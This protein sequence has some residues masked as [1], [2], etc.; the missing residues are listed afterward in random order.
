MPEAEAAPKM[1][2]E[3]IVLNF[4]S[5]FKVDPRVSDWLLAEGILDCE[6]I[7]S[8]AATEELVDAKFI[9]PLISAVVET[10]KSRAKQLR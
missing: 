4:I 10:L 7:A 1:E 2:V 9:Q 6:G 3:A 8:I 5:A